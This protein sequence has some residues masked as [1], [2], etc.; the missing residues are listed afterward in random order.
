MKK[1]K[2][3]ITMEE[4]DVTL[5]SESDLYIKFGIQKLLADRKILKQF[6]KQH[7]EFKSSFKPLQYKDCPEIVEQMINA[8]TL[9]YVGPM[10]AVAGALADSMGIYMKEKGA[11]ISVIENGGEVF[12]S[13]VEDIYIALYSMTTILKGKVGF[14]FRGKQYDIG[15]GTSSGTFGHA[16]SL[17]KADTVTVFA[18]NAAIG[19]AAATRIANE[20]NG[21]DIEGSVGK[22]LEIADDLEN[23][24]GV[25][26]SRG[27]FIGKS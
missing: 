18:I 7:S 4:S 20:V 1:I 9:T 5:I 21:E 25:L 15:L 17:G 19:D 11:Q 6:I 16:I 23:V 24:H 12:I 13:S 26:I 3:H 10:A 2:K 14:L 22:G 8:S 27:K